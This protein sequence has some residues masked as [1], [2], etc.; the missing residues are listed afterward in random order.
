MRQVLLATALTAALWPIVQASHATTLGVVPV[1]TSASPVSSDSQVQQQTSA[2]LAEGMRRY[3]ASGGAAVILDVHTGQIVSLVS[4]VDATAG[5][6][7]NRGYNRA[8][9]NVNELGSV[10]M[11]F[12]IAQALSEGLLDPDSLID[13]PESLAAG[14]YVQI[15]DFA[16]FEAQTSLRDV[17][18]RSSKVASEELV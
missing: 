5:A 2:A 6:E 16:H 11:I 14:R 1:E 17:F 7:V 15:R 4:L 10:M 9:N 13:T 3:G 8:I 18:V 12:P